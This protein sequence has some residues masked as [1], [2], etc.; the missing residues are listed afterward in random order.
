MCVP[1]YCMA[2]GIRYEY[3]NT[4]ISLE[5]GGLHAV[6]GNLFHISYSIVLLVARLAMTL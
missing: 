3:A 6:A 2:T 1:L 5:D 4:L